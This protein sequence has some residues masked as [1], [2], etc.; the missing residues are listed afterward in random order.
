MEFTLLVIALA[1]LFVLQPRRPGKTWTKEQ[2]AAADE[3]FKRRHDAATVEV[4][5]P[6]DG[7]SIEDAIAES[8][9]STSLA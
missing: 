4:I 5:M 9:R 7:Q 6:K 1:V 3:N 2:Q 8:V